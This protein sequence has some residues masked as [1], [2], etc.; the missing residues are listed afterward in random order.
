MSVPGPTCLVAL[1][2]DGWGVA[3]AAI[4]GWI[5][6]RVL[7]RLVAGAA[8]PKPAALLKPGGFGL[9]PLGIQTVCMQVAAAAAAAAVWWWEVEARGLM[10]APEPTAGSA[11]SVAALAGRAAAHIVLFAFLAAA[12]WI[13]LRQRVIPDAITV[14]GVLLG[15]LWI[16]VAP[17]SL[18]PVST[19]EP[20][21]FAAPILRADVLGGGGGLEAVPPPAWM[22]AGNALLGLAVAS[23]IFLV[24]WLVCTAPDEPGDGADDP[25]RTGSRL[26]SVISPRFLVLAVGMTCIVTAWC[27]GGLHWRGLVS[28]LLGILVSAGVIWLTRAGASWAFGQEAMGMGDVTLMAMAGSWL[29]WQPCVVACCLAVFIGLVHACVQLVRHRD[30][31]LPFGPSLCLGIAATVLCWRPIWQRVE[32]CFE[33]P[34]ETA[35]GI[36]LVIALTA[37]SLGLL[38]WMRPRQPG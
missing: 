33:Q 1:A 11:G 10:P 4:G 32:F 23:G 9:Q 7:G 14:P 35:A 27:L 19:A 16:A 21:T 22:S 15:L 25:P 18:L 5:L 12:A 3:A 6:G 17:S 24:W 29:G 30:H 31:E 36:A 26:G 37:A 38:R 2:T 34:L 20:R 13:D 8:A 28:S